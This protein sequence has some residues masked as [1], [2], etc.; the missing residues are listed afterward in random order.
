M[1]RENILFSREVEELLVADIALSLA[2]ALIFADF[3]SSY[4]SLAYFL[5]IA[6][7]VVPLTFVLHEL[8]HKFV[9][10]HYGAIA[11]FRY[12]PI[13]LVITLASSMFG[14]LI[15][16]PGATVIYTN[17]FTR[18]ED[19]IVSLAGPLTNFAIF[20]IFFIAG[21]LLYKGFLGNVLVTFS[22]YFTNYS[23]LHN[24][25]NVV[26]FISLWLAFFNMLPIMP[27]DGSKVLRWNKGIY[28][29]TMLVIFILLYLIVPLYSILFSLVFILVFALIF[30]M[31]YK[32]MMFRL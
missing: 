5:P 19:G 16:L 9:A 15:G 21:M 12:S 2:F 6:F 32:G 8:M 11:A 18:R 28:A 1:F 17:R 14:F 29:A 23:Y 25:I 22:P 30:S 20:A 3:T 26:L 4:A 27:L 24:F 13:G 7:I 10:Q 31:I